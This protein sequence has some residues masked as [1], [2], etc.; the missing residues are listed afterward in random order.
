[1]DGYHLWLQWIPQVEKER[2]GRLLH[3]FYLLG[4]TVPH[5]DYNNEFQ[6]DLCSCFDYHLPVT[7]C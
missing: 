2:K 3:F 5:T 4:D 6:K 1:M 7:T